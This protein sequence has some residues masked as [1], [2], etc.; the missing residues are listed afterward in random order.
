MDRDLQT[1]IEYSKKYIR[2]YSVEV[3]QFKVGDT[4]ELKPNERYAELVKRKS[5]LSN[6]FFSS[7]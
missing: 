6:R 5:F 7:N 3:C 2:K 4:F 1:K